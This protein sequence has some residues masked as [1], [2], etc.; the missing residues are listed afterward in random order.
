M[1]TGKSTFVSSS[2]ETWYLGECPLLV[3]CAKIWAKSDFW[4]TRYSASKSWNWPFSNCI[5]PGIF[6]CPCSPL[7]QFFN[8][9][10][11]F[12]MTCLQ[13]LL[14]CQFDVNY[15]PADF[16]PWCWFLLSRWGE[17]SEWAQFQ[18]FAYGRDSWQAQKGRYYTEWDEIRWRVQ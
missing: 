4:V 17:N 7:E 18:Y 16:Q 8:L 3:C 10:L 12:H 2:D 5:F 6:I 15:L 14:T 9:D 13:C 11:H 1:Y